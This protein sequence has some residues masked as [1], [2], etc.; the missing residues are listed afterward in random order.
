MNDPVLPDPKPRTHL[1]TREVS[2]RGYKRDDGLWD[3]EAQMSDRRAYAYTM[4]E[5]GLM[6]AGEP[7]HNMAVRLSVDDKWVIRE[8]VSAMAN[9]P[10]GE[11][12]Q[13]LDPMQALVGASVGRGWRQT[14]DARIGGTLGCTHMR[15]LLFGLATVVYQTIPSYTK[16]QQRLAGVPDKV[17]S[18]EPVPQYLGQCMSWNFNGPVVA[19]HFPQYINWPARKAAGKTD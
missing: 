6:P 5:K 19:R 9:I 10:F 7:V 11:C 4:R 18:G 15:E 13:T 2:Y 8:V 3:F 16:L 1:H 14:I 17:P 12:R